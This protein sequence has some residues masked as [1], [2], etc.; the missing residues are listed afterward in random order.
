MLT[1]PPATAPVQEQ[2]GHRHWQLHQG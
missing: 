1:L 2:S